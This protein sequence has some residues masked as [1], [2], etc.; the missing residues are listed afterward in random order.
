MFEGHG[1]E[2]HV[3]RTRSK[4]AT[5]ITQLLRDG[6]TTLT[7]DQEPAKSDEPA[8]TEA[9]S[10]Q[11]PAAESSVKTAEDAIA[12]KAEE[13]NTDEIEVKESA[14][15]DPTKRRLER[16]LEPVDIQEGSDPGTTK[17]SVFRSLPRVQI[18]V[19]E[20]GASGRDV[21]KSHCSLT[22]LERVQVLPVF[23]SSTGLICDSLESSITDFDQRICP[24]V[25]Q[26]C[27]NVT[28]EACQ[29]AF[30]QPEETQTVV[31][32]PCQR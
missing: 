1:S 2:A 9:V 5:L 18:T 6:L 22:V 16:A 7:S 15:L 28:S 3:W 20:K 29:D 25:M 10:A 19:P 32:L 8:T 23:E 12:D 26:S 27:G 24:T 21:P 4:D 11:E 13:P 17:Q 14:A 31:C 30:H